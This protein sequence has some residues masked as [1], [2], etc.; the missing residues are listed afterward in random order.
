MVYR[1]NAVTPGHVD[2]VQF[3]RE[4]DDN[5]LQLWLDTQATYCKS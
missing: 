4:T 3:R 2:I 1:V 5:S